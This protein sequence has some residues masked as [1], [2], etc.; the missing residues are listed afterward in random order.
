MIASVKIVL[1]LILTIKISTAD[2]QT[3]RKTK[4]WEVDHGD[5]WTNMGKNKECSKTKAVVTD[6][7]EGIMYVGGQQKYQ[8]FV[9]PMDGTVLLTDNS[10]LL[11]EDDPK[12]KNISE[13]EFTMYKHS[14]VRRWFSSD[15]W[16]TI[17]EKKNVAMP[18]IERIPCE[19]DTVV[20]PPE[21]GTAVDLDDVDDLVVDQIYINGHVDDFNAFL[22]TKV[23]QR[24]FLN[25]EDVRFTR[26]KCTDNRNCG[27][28]S[29][30]RF[31]D[32]LSILCI[33][34]SEYCVIPHCKQPI[35]PIG[36]CCDVCGAILTLENPDACDI[37]LQQMG[38]SVQSK[39][40]RFRNGRHAADLD[41][42]ISIVPYKHQVML[43]LVV[44]ET[45]EYSGIST[46]FM[47]Y[48][49]KDPNFKGNS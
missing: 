37:D 43:Q 34:E 9:L 24:M 5:K 14:T 23:G 44:A 35:R 13:N 26:G 7:L 48:L 17:D 1:V 4:V 18:H 45:G 21:S 42:Y 30:K 8:E 11:F 28:H 10:R 29:N 33:E 49:T 47:D 36:H 15:S 16:H 41:Y 19:C 3:K 39:L 20:F 46:E 31:F 27:C 40:N 38:R 32:Q 12:C 25:S 6:H 22:E 2:I